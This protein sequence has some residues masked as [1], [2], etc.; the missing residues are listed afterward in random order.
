MD[1]F[2]LQD[3]CDGDVMEWFENLVNDAGESF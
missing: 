1:L 3:I 2:D